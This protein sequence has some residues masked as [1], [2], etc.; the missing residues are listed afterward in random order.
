MAPLLLEKREQRSQMA[1]AKK[2]HNLKVSFDTSKKAFILEENRQKNNLW[3]H[4]QI[5]PLQS[6]EY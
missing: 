1:T 6:F 4:T 2:R 5:Q 3:N